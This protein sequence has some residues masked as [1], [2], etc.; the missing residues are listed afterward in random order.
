MALERSTATLSTWMQHTASQGGAAS[1]AAAGNGGTPRS[2]AQSKVENFR[3]LIDQAARRYHIDA[4]LLSAV[5]EVESA[6]NPRAVSPAGAQGL[7]QLM[8]GTARDLGVQDA[9]DPA[10][11]LHGAAKYLQQLL[12]QFKGD[13]SKALA[14]YNA[15]P[16]NVQK[17]GGIPPFAETQAYVPAVLTAYN[18]YS[19]QPAPTVSTASATSL[20]SVESPTLDNLTGPGST[21]ETP[22]RLP[23]LLE[24]AA[25]RLQRLQPS[26]DTS[27]IV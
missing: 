10:Q 26:R 15:G 13:V 7:A 16:G 11:N 21:G 4:A 24:L 3:T 23:W 20:A 14:A 12:G 6:G 5:V 18:A 19:Q 22:F 25:L 1:K 8:P 2:T 17:Y 27:P 9:L